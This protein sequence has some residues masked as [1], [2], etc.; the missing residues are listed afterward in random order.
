[1]CPFCNSTVIVKLL[2][3]GT[4]NS[5]Q[6]LASCFLYPLPVFWQ[7]R[8]CCLCA[9]VSGLVPHTLGKLAQGRYTIH[10]QF[11]H[12]ILFYYYFLCLGLRTPI[13]ATLDSHS[14]TLTRLTRRLETNS[15]P[16]DSETQLPSLRNRPHECG[17]SH[18]VW[19]ISAS[20]DLSVYENRVG[21]AAPC[22]LAEMMINWRRP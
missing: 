5:N 17:R 9:G 7:K 18:S 19:P 22:A 6:C 14:Q 20:L 2:K 16:L 12:R 13:V 8:H 11:S 15:S 1:L 4:Q 3:E 21:L 10:M